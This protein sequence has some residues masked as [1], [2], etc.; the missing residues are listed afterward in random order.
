MSLLKLQPGFIEKE[1]VEFSLEHPNNIDEDFTL[2]KTRARG[3]DGGWFNLFVMDY[4]GGEFEL[5]Y[6]FE[7]D[8]D[9]SHIIRAAK[10]WMSREHEIQEHLITVK[11]KE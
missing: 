5:I 9:I 6:T 3:E 4:E 10:D 7:P 2:I 8:A 11:T 1:C